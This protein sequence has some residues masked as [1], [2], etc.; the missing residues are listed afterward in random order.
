MPEEAPETRTAFGFVEA[1]IALLSQ[2][3]AFAYHSIV[4]P[5][6]RRRC[7]GLVDFS[8]LPVIGLGGCGT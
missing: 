1:V 6:D 7:R 4:R 2:C 3:E 5:F 8:A